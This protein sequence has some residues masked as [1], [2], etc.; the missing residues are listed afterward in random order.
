[1]TLFDFTPGKSAS[2]KKGQGDNLHAVVLPVDYNIIFV[3]TFHMNHA[4]L[5]TNILL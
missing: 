5:T 1:M 2:F 4:R 3:G